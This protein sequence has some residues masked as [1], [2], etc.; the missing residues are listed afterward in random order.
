MLAS[1]FAAVPKA[2][3]SDRAMQVRLG[4]SAPIIPIAQGQGVTITFIPSHQIVQKVWLD[5]PSWLTVDTDGCLEGLGTGKCDESR[6]TSIHLRRIKPLQIEG[7]PSTGTS[8][9][10]V[11][12]RDV[13]GE[14][15]ISTFRLQAATSPQH[16]LVEVVPASG[17][18]LPDTVNHVLVQR[19]RDVAISQGWLRKNDRLSQKIDRFLAMSQTEPTHLAAERAGISMALIERLSVL[20]AGQE[21]QGGQGGQ[22]RERTMP[23]QT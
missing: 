6:A 4:N 22:G 23:S 20:G 3:A 12:S 18:K 7:L 5:N 1:L 15:K 11:I 14:L 16:S 9:L 8:L 21:R 10:T 17:L 19:G 13:S 2:I